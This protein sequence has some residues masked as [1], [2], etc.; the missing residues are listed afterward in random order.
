VGGLAAGRGGQ[1]K[2]QGL[3]DLLQPF[4]Q[5]HR[6]HRSGILDVKLS[7]AVLDCPAG[8]RTFR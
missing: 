5:F 3:V 1:V 8:Q 6:Q 7:Q 2:D 4:K